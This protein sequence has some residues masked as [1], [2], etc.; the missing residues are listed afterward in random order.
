MEHI[1]VDKV[2]DFKIEFPGCEQ[3]R[4][5]FYDYDLAFGDDL[6]GETFIDLEDRYFS[7]DWT[8]Y[9]HKPIEK[10]PLTTEELRT[11]QGN[12]YM[13][14]DIIPMSSKPS[15]IVKWQTAPKPGVPIEARI[16]VWDSKD[17][18]MMDNEGTSDGYVKCFFDSTKLSKSTDTHWRNSDGKMSWNWRML[19]PV[20]QHEEDKVLVI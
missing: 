8:C 12:V 20:D 2:W 18:K 7:A 1:R 9:A 6:I 13:W 19:F 15:K 16:V 3:L 14:V 11:S 10:R 5:A 4:V 17:M